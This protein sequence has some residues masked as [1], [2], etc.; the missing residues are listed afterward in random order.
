M[1]NIN[2]IDTLGTSVQGLSVQAYTSEEGWSKDHVHQRAVIDESHSKYAELKSLREKKRVALASIDLVLKAW[3]DGNEGFE[4]IL[5][6]AYNYKQYLHHIAHDNYEGI[7]FH[8]FDDL[9]IRK[10]FRA[11]FK[12]FAKSNQAVLYRL[13]HT[14]IQEL[15]NDIGDEAIKAVIK[16]VDEQ[17][18]VVKNKIHDKMAKAIRESGNYASV[19]VEGLH[20]NHKSQICYTIL[21][22][23]Y[24]MTNEE[25]EERN[26]RSK[27][28]VAHQNFVIAVEF[29]SDGRNN[30]ASGD[31][32]SHVKQ[33]AIGHI[34][35]HEEDGKTLRYFVEEDYV[36]IRSG[37]SS[38]NFQSK[39]SRQIKRLKLLLTCV[40]EMAEIENNAVWARRDWLSEVHCI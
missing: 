21:H 3:L 37:G 4:K 1:S 29:E 10:A 2:I 35:S 27:D 36:Y 32:D 17:V 6:E 12:S 19:E 8:N 18:N 28:K 9:G 23:D 26:K 20:R 5:A 24:L 38:L 25:H 33:V 13:Y 16:H 7:E 22:N 30:Y 15:E 11:S 14:K 40:M 31:K 39:D 34:K